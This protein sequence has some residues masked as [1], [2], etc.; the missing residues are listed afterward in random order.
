MRDAATEFLDLLINSRDSRQVKNALYIL[1]DFHAF[2]SNI[3]GG[4]NPFTDLSKQYRVSKRESASHRRLRDD[5][6]LT[7]KEVVK[8]MGHATRIA[9]DSRHY[10]ELGCAKRYVAVR[11]WF[12]LHMLSEYGMRIDALTKANVSDIDFANR[13]FTIHASKNQ[14]PY[15]VPIK[16]SIPVI[17]SYLEC[18]HSIMT[19]Y[20]LTKPLLLSK[21]G[22]RLSNTSARR[23]INC[24]A[25]DVGLYKTQ[26]SAHQL[27]H[28]RATK[29][30]KEGM[31]QSL[32]ATIMGMSVNTLRS[33]YLH[34]TDHDTV[35]EYE[36][37]AN[38][39]NS[40]VCPNCGFQPVASQSH[41]LKVV[42][43]NYLTASI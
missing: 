14:T 30:H 1:A 29:Y 8:M 2:I 27:R 35:A 15:P 18:R 4:K 6:A 16:T 17:R 19:G 25:M 10:T 3:E 21:F 33:T 12:I 37:W 11:N 42:S 5:R 13:K 40:W 23:A 24:I 22:T 38:S 9:S 32:I 43:K 39:R 26:R 28:Y 36:A 31:R 7:Q 41:G 34:L 20:A